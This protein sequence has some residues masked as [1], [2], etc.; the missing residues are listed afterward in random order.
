MVT[1]RAIAVWLIIMAVESV[2]GMVR[3]MAVEPLVGDMRARQISVFTASALILVVTYLTVLWLRVRQSRT[4]LW[5]GALWIL[6]TLLFEVLVGRLVLGL[7]WER[8]LS[9][10]NIRRGGLMPFGL[11]VMLVAP[12]IIARLRGIGPDVPGR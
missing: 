7:S 6:L 12:L 8:I 2:H 10:Y 11:V 4:L 1:I 5:V 9:D 3:I